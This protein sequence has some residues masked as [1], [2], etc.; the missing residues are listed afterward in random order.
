MRRLNEYLF[1][2]LQFKAGALNKT[3]IKIAEL[4][5]TPTMYFVIPEEL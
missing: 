1:V 4:E 5:C 2:N 3:T